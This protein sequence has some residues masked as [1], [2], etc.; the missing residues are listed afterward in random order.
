MDVSTWYPMAFESHAKTQLWWP[1][2]ITDNA[3]IHNDNEEMVKRIGLGKG[4]PFKGQWRRGSPA[5]SA[6]LSLH[7]W[8]QEHMNY[9]VFAQLMIQGRRELLFEVAWQALLVETNGRPDQHP[10]LQP[11]GKSAL[12]KNPTKRYMS[13][14]TAG[15]QRDDVIAKIKEIVKKSFLRI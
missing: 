9:K 14:S 6:A 2:R 7:A 12:K 11:I 5:T 15:M 8:L 13:N 4:N 3:W 1:G 10:R